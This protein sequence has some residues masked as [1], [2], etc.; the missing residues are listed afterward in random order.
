MQLTVERAGKKETVEVDPDLT[1]VAIGGKTFPVRVVSSG[2]TKVELEIAGERVVV[3]NWPEHF[4]QPPGPV[5]VGGER[6]KVTIVAGPSPA[7]GAPPAPAARWA[8]APAAAPSASTGE[9]VP[10]LPPMPGKII[11]VRVREGDV[12]RKGDVL[13]HLE[14]MKM[15]NEIASPAD[16]IVRGLRVSAGANVRAAEPMLFV[17]PAP[18]KGSAP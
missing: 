7:V 17:A 3:D 10:V 2:A 4:P 9:G 12:V 11:E 6:W 18:A 15:V 14:A 8:A 16:G 5:D 13:L 1:S